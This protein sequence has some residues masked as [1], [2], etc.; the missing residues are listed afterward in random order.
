MWVCWGGGG[1]KTSLVHK[2]T[3]NFSSKWHGETNCKCLV[4]LAVPRTGLDAWCE[5]NNS[6]ATT[7]EC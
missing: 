7:V 4:S 5:K 1:E 6:A 2:R 3:V